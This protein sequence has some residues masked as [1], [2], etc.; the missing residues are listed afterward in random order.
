MTST[1]ELPSNVQL[2]EGDLLESEADAIVNTVNT[3][4]VMGK[5]IA[6]Q[7][8]RRYKHNYDVY[9]RACEAGEVRI[10]HML[11]VPVSGLEGPS[12]IINFPTKRHW[13]A[14]S[15]LGDIREGLVDFVRVV[16]GLG[17]DSVAIPPLGAGNGGLNWADVRPV[18]LEALGQVPDVRFVLFEPKS[19]VR[20]VDAKELNLS[21]SRAVLLMLLREYV[22]RRQAIDP[23]E[24]STGA[25][26]LEI[27]KL[28][29][30]ADQAEPRL[31][32]R[33]SAGHYGPYSDIVRIMVSEMEGWYLVGH[34]DGSQRVLDLK[35]I[36][37]TEHAFADLAAFE[38]TAEGQRLRVDVVDPVL[39][40]I[41][42]FESVLTLELLASV[43]WASR[44]TSNRDP[45]IVH[46][47]IANWTN[48]KQR[49]FDR[50][51]VE[52]AIEQL[53]G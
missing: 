38:K 5:G 37:L 6:L 13:R 44:Q 16:K 39:H 51:Q 18:I 3:V 21:P 34:G 29:Y 25:S 42:G 53:A 15:K 33:F 1:S 35:P 12:W 23:W 41:E 7:F 9:R 48:R 24:S 45:E 32:L 8:K 17:V 10:G 30:F 36:A 31:N 20:S 4:G 43:H 27:Q 40:L 28:M 49:L 14:D 46:D 26:V 50:R 22:R 47:Y 19:G 11:V 52:V 2:G